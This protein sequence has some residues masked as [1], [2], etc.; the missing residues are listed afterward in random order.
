MFRYVHFADLC[1]DNS[2]PVNFVGNAQSKNQTM[3][4]RTTTIGRVN[5]ITHGEVIRLILSSF[6]NN[7]AFKTS[8]K[9]VI[10]KIISNRSYLTNN[11]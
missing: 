2:E 11:K 7:M 6:I 3:V 1:G 5:P 10:L 9:I 4:M 8:L